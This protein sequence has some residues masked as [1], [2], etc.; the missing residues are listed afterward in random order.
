VRAAVE[1]LQLGVEQYLRELPDDE[2]ADLVRAVRPPRS[3]RYPAKKRRKTLQDTG[4]GEV[5]YGG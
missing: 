3:A 5:S 4:V 2:F 1:F